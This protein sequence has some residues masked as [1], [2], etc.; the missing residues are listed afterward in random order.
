MAAVRRLCT[1]DGRTLEAYFDKVYVS[2]EMKLLKPS[3]EI[4][5]AVLADSALRAE[6]TLFVD[7]SERNVATARSLGF[8]TYCP[9]NGE[10]FT[11]MLDAIPAPGIR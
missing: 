7:D 2:C 5:R 8:A 4:F 10:D 9:K 11:P 1:V 3:P 6:E